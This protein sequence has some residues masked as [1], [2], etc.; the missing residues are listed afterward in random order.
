M[1]CDPPY[2]VRHNYNGFRKYNE[3]IFSWADQER[4]A[5]SLREHRQDVA[6]YR[7][8]ATL[9]TDV[10]LPERLA[11]LE[12][13]GARRDQLEAVLARIGALELADRVPRWRV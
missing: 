4:L 5:A 8:L 7:Q 10:P 13:Q 9:R 1:F 2:T 6:L 12:W 11:D 3:V